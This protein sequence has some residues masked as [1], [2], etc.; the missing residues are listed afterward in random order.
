[1]ELKT[2]VHR[3]QYYETDQMGCVHH[4]NYIRWFEESRIDLLNQIGCGYAVM[5]QEGIISPVLS[6]SCEYKSM[7]H[8]D[9]EVYIKPIMESYNGFRF[10]IRYEITDKKS[11]VVRVTGN[12]THC[13]LD[14]NNR[15]LS[16]KRHKPHI[17]EILERVAD[18][19]E[20]IIWK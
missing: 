12:S 13:F 3:A 17:H 18:N 2:Y 9:E 6:V 16:L 7:T 19:S 10:S 4:S 14:K 5:E 11:G 20:E 15:P 8:F 1:M